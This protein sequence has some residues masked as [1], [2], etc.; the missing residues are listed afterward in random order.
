MKKNI[1][2][3][4]Q[5]ASVFLVPADKDYLATRLLFGT[6]SLTT[7]AAY[8]A[9]Q[10][11]EKYLKA[12]TVQEDKKYLKGHDLDVLREMASNYNTY[13]SQTDCKNELAKFNVF[14]QVSRYS[15]EASYDPMKNT[16]PE[17]KIKG[18]L[19]FSFEHL[20]LLDKLV[21]EI[22]QLFDFTKV[23]C[24]DSLKAILEDRKDVALNAT[25]KLPIPL[26][27]ILTFKN[28]FFK[29]EINKKVV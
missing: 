12:F 17:F 26:K 10:S 6:G 5:P 2:I 27:T 29:K 28:D 23:K 9:Q 25:W 14:D 11:L 15:A 20:I 7:L 24:P 1:I 4:D 3:T 21:C 19:F 18:V 8:H 16:T 13:F 22:R